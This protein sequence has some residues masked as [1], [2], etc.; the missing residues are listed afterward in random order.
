MLPVF[1]PVLKVLSGQFRRVKSQKVFCVRCFGVVF[2]VEAA[3]ENRRPVDNHDFVVIQEV[4]WVR[5]DRHLLFD[6]PVPETGLV[7]AFLFSRRT[8]T[9]MPRFLASA[10]ALAMSLS[11]SLYAPT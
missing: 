7:F 6:E 8:D 10:R 5:I 4:F 11:S 9:A 2:E 3:C 1:F